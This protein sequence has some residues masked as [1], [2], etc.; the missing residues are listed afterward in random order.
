MRW[1]DLMFMHWPVPAAALRPLIPAG[2]EV[3]TYEGRAWIG[4]VPFRMSGI[5]MRWMPPV[6]GT[7]A[8][9]ELN[10]R[11]YVTTGGKPGVWFFSLDA[12]N[13]LAVRA[14][15]WTFHLPYFDAR[16]HCTREPAAGWVDYASV[17]THRAAPPAGYRARYRPIGDARNPLPGTLEYFLTERYCL[18]SADRGGR[19]YRGD[20]AHPPWCLRDAEA[21]VEQ[22]SMLE[23]LGLGAVSRE[24]PLLHFAGDQAVRAWAV[25]PVT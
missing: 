7:S 10:V 15:R 25:K 11:T 9:P 21:E 1:H 4:V 6:P 5:R 13:K 18:Y 8:F 14:A 19:V 12:T 22:N 2:L 23:P 3:D 17:R 16:M 20:I 24:I